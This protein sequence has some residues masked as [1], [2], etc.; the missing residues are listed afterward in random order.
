VLSQLVSIVLPVYL[1]AG[2]GFMWVRVGRHYDTRFITE[3]V[4]WIGA[5]CLTFSS[6]VGVDLSFGQIAHM[7]GATVIATACLG[8]VAALVLRGAGL[9]LSTFLAPMT[10]GNTGN[11]GIPICYFAFGD[12]GLALGVCFYAATALLHFTIGQ[13]MWSGRVGLGQLAR[14]PLTWATLLAFAVK[15]GGVPVP[16]WLMRSTS[17]LGD[18]T[19]PLMQLT[20]GVSLAQIL[21]SRIPRNLAL[22]SLKL[23]LGAAVGFGVASALGLEGVARGVVVL[24]C[25]M[26]V[27]VFN[28]MFASMFDR[29]PSDVAS[30][31]VL[32][33]LLSFATLPL[34]LTA[35]L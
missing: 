34:V 28:Y 30:V 14:T 21:P 12:V 31:V 27:A 4:M 7:A 11:M 19:I 29:S 10:F 22:A 35:V 6:L 8:I 18:F 20:L 3:L 25:A 5:P 2:L 26:P 24:D 1:C 32:S 9:P 16:E 13:W 17:L 23:G 15:G 33:T